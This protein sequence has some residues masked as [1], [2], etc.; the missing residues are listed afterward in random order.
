MF[1]TDH[2]AL[3]VEPHMKAVKQPSSSSSNVGLYGSMASV[4]DGQEAGDE[5]G[6]I[7]RQGGDD[8]IIAEANL[9]LRHQLDH[10]QVR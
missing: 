1:L 6:S 5:S 4:G 2:L 7:S 8:V 9:N 3:S 10:V